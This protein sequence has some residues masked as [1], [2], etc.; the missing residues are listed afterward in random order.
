MQSE[1]KAR[2]VEREWSSWYWVVVVVGDNGDSAEKVGEETTDYLAT[3]VNI[4]R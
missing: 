1:Q 2:V 4:R 3:A